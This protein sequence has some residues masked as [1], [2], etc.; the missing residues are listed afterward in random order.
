MKTVSKIVIFH[1]D[2]RE[3]GVSEGYSKT[4]SPRQHVSHSGSDAGK[5]KKTQKSQLVQ[6]QISGH[7]PCRRYRIYMFQSVNLP[8]TFLC[9]LQ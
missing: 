2:V 8:F 7:F 4:L 6:L 1:R 9:R 5:K 3:N